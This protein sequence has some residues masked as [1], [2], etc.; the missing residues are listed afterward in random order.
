MYTGA[1][2]KKSIENS[3]IDSELASLS[4][5]EEQQ[6]IRFLLAGNYL[7]L[8]KLNNQEEVIVKNIEQTNE[9]N[10]YLNNLVLLTEMLDADNQRLAAQLDVEN[11]KINIL[12][13]FYHLKKI[14]G[15]L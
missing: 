11:A 12:Y 1:A 10:R 15:T 13:H 9:L 2:L 7:E 5:K 4:L 3:E 14:S 6:N 8:Q